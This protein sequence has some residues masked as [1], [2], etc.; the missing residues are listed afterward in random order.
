MLSRVAPAAAAMAKRFKN[1]RRC[2][3]AFD[4][5][6]E[7]KQAAFRYIGSLVFEIAWKSRRLTSL[8]IGYVTDMSTLSEFIDSLGNDR[9]TNLG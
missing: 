1:S 5:K 7:V 8:G 9:H 3:P 4:H 2:I 6:W